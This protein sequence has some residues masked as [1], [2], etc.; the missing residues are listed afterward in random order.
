MTDY[1]TLGLF[2]LGRPFDVERGAPGEGLVL[3]D[4]RDLVTHALC[5]GMTGSGKTGLC[6]AL[7]EEAALDGIPAL[8]IDPKGDLGNLL[9]TFPEL[10]PEDFRPWVNVDDAR[11]KGLDPD[12][13]AA[14]QAKAW[15]EGLAAWGQDGERI[16]RLQAAADFVVFTPGSTAGRPL[17]VLDS[18]A[19][20]PAAVRED[21]ELLRE[22]IAST[23][24]SLLALLGVDADP[25]RSREHVLLST[26]LAEAWRAGR[27][28][29]LAAL[30]GQIRTP[31]IA[32]LGVI[33]LESAFPAKDRFELAMSLNTLLAAPGFA[34]W[35][36]GDPL[37]VGR[38]LYTPEGKPRV[39]VVSIAHLS[40]AERMFLVSLLLSQVIAWMRGQAGTTSLRAIVYMDEIFGYFPP[41]ANPPS[42]GPLLTL[43]KQARAFG[44]GVVLATQNPVD[45]D[46]KGLANCGTW[47]IGRLQTERDRARVLDGLEGA[48]PAG[49]DRA[50]LERMLS[51]LGPRIF[52]LHN[53][54]D[55]E[56][57]VFE[58]RWVMSYLRGPLAR[59][60]IRR[61]MEGRRETAPAATGAAA[62]SPPGPPG[63]GAR[64]VL[65]PEIPQLFAPIRGARTPGTAVTYRPVLLGTARVRFVDARAGVDVTR[66]VVY[67]APL[68]EGALA[69]DWERAEP[70]DAA[71][72]DLA[73][74]PEEPALFV[75]LPAAA[76]QPK[77]YDAR[78]KAFAA[79]LH[80]TQVLPLHRHAASGIVSNPGEAE[81][82]FR[83]RLAQE[84]RERRDAAVEALR[85]RYAS[86]IEAL[87]ERIRRADQAV[88]RETEQAQQEKVQAAISIGMTLLGSFLGRKRVSSGTIGR[89]GTA[90]RGVGRSMRQAGD[91]RRAEASAAA[92]RQD[93]AELE[94]EF[95]REAQALERRFD[96]A[97]AP[98]ETVSLEPARGNVEVRAVGLGWV[99]V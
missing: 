26:I 50:R 29:D 91:V 48:A 7:L 87:E 96:A 92:L 74:A 20:P 14:E 83:I 69:G 93:L 33:D 9:L 64:P 97:S 19:A 11:R 95:E 31:P 82:E 77:A 17:S 56:P 13:Y 46:Y 36:E 67:A 45:L 16:R 58:T 86:R 15:R 84:A 54:H 49:F 22:R 21:E 55:D 10:R 3:Y 24:T 61:L 73:S 30:V 44:L 25:V 41:V 40:D 6:I 70:L 23:A 80:R 88:A 39:A 81:R 94:A 57:T 71:E 5:V 1:E 68:G 28:L 72:E 2:Y 60:E 79:W 38:L 42:K 4:S 65:P 76:A 85:K 32:K 62:A 8:V 34:A 18:F 27:D 12:A 52:Y 66:P 47:F 59:P 99:P 75:E 53:V 35:L 98:I 43:L 89:A 37:D 63:G 90:A 78:R 51:S